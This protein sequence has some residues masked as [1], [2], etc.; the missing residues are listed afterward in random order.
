MKG[1]NRMP[2]VNTTMIKD[3]FEDTVLYVF[4]M[5][6]AC[7]NANL[8]EL[9][10]IID[11]NQHTKDPQIQE[12]T[13]IYQLFLQR[14][15][16]EITPH[17]L[18]KSVQYKTSDQPLMFC[19]YRLL[20]AYSCYDNRELGVLKHV[21]VQI[22]D[23][24]EKIKDSC[25]EPFYH[26][27]LCQLLSN[28]YLSQNEVD[29]VREHAYVI[30]NYCSTQAYIASAYHTLGISYLFEDYDKGIHALQMALDIYE[31]LGELT[32]INNVKRSIVFFNNYWSVIGDLMIYSNQ[33][34]DIHERA[35]AEVRKENKKKAIQLLNALEIDQFGYLEMGYHYFYMG[36]ATD[37]VDYLYRSIE[38]F[39]KINY[40]F[41][42][43]MARVELYERGERPTAIEAAYN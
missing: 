4:Q 16:G 3:Y 36:L 5:E 23:E 10:D 31:E 29:K 11:L 9:Q 42:A 1:L 24:L 32:K 2:P 20:H 6:E 35:H 30:I 40:K 27:R 33:T 19:A 43:N 25:V 17:D 15:R 12:W 38:A 39:K 41:A 14:L 26:F 18:L 28:Y 37:N 21:L 7:F 13:S 34:R 8:D 22:R